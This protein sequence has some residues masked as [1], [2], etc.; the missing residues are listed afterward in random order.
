MPF[1]AIWA[2]NYELQFDF[3]KR[4]T[5]EIVPYW[6]YVPVDQGQQWC[7]PLC[8]PVN[9][10]LMTIRSDTLVNKIEVLMNAST[11]ITKV[12]LVGM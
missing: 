10:R 4:K 7:T 1:P 5:L 12:S 6:L 3:K 8:N 11:M 2:L 9:P